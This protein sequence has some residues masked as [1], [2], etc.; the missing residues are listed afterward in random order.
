MAPSFLAVAAVDQRES[1]QQAFAPGRVDVVDPGVP[2]A[3]VVTVGRVVVPVLAA[4]PWR[5][6]LWS[7]ALS[8]SYCRRSTFGRS[9][10]TTPATG[11]DVR[12]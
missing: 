7:V 12:I 4:G 10:T 1:G 8:R 11:D 6:A 9:L 3:Q 5:A 2:A